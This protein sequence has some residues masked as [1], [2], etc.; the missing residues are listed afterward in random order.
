MALNGKNNNLVLYTSGII[1]SQPIRLQHTEMHPYYFTLS[2]IQKFYRVQ[3][4]DSYG[5]YIWT[6]TVHIR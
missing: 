2:N 3:V 1:A 6:T 5:T 4:L